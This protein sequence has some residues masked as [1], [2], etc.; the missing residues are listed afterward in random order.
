MHRLAFTPLVALW[1]LIA[2]SPRAVGPSLPPGGGAVVSSHE[3]ADAGAMH[4]SAPAW[5]L[6]TLAQA[7]RALPR[8]ELP[9]GV[10]PSHVSALPSVP[11]TVG[12]PAWHAATSTSEPQRHYPLFP[13]GPPRVQQQA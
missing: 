8:G 5:R 12:R 2:S 13:T 1:A 9:G 6:L 10:L 3:F 4:R 7:P 11:L